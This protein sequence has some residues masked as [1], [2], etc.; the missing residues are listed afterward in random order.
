MIFI[1]NKYTTTYLNL[2]NKA[3]L[4]N[5]TS[6]AQAKQAI[7]YSE[8][9]HIIP[10]SLGGDDSL[11]NLVF[12]TAKEHFICHLLLPKMLSGCAKSKMVH[13]L[14]CIINQES[15][16]QYRYKINSRLYDQIKQENSKLLSEAR[17]GKPNLASRGT[18]KSEEHRKKISIANSGKNNPNYGKSRPEHSIAMTGK[19]NPMFGRTGNDHPLFGT[20]RS[21]DTCTKI[22][23]NRW[24]A[25]KRARQSLLVAERWKNEPTLVCPH[26]SKEGRGPTM[27]KYH[28]NKCKAK[29][30]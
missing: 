11:E 23:E 27:Y 16:K 30:S 17:L 9:H 26:C 14:W 3:Q 12:L 21:A 25:D 15:S 18:P 19:N 6:K 20:S 13:A 1:D 8:R 2:I 4:R 28:F 7:G 10:R 24:D 5:I 29:L 22:R